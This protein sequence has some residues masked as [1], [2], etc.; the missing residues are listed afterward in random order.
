MLEPHDPPADNAIPGRNR[1]TLHPNLQAAIIAGVTSIMV[2]V[3][4][5]FGSIALTSNKLNEQ[6]AAVAALRAEFER[7]DR[8]KDR[9]VR[10]L[11]D[12]RW[13]C[14]GEARLASAEF[15]GPVH[16]ATGFD[17]TL[18]RGNA[19]RYA[20]IFRKFETP[21]ASPPKLYYALSGFDWPL[22]DD[23]GGFINP[24]LHIWLHTVD[25]NGFELVVYSN[26]GSRSGEA[27]VSWLALRPDA[28]AAGE[29]QH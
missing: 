21:F 16:N 5:T 2:A 19:I 20:R 11:S 23:A 12:N 22:T 7:L 4:A 15:S 27:A 3:I 17:P 25:E 24:R 1:F 26:D 8:E 9:I 6:R 28:V 29:P 10:E 13:F 18:P 14:Q